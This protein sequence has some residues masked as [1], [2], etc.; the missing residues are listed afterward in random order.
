MDS[1]SKGRRFESSQ[2]RHF[3]PPVDPNIGQAAP[4][5]LPVLTGLTFQAIPQFLHEAIMEEFPG[6]HGLITNAELRAHDFQ[7]F[8]VPQGILGAGSQFNLTRLKF[9]QWM[10]FLS[11]E[12]IAKEELILVR[13]SLTSCIW[14]GVH[15]PLKGLAGGSD[16]LKIRS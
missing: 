12:T 11:L 9:V 2:A 6:V 16:D 5:L 8:D 3:N 14:A 7:D 10:R 13:T 1:G 15:R 4:F